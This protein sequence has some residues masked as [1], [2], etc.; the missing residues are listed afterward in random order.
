MT[1]LHHALIGVYAPLN[2]DPGNQGEGRREYCLEVATA[3]VAAAMTRGLCGLAAAVILGEDINGEKLQL[4]A[5]FCPVEVGGGGG[6][7][8]A[9]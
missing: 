3:V 9:Q 4:S 7:C 8:G 6:G 2:H 1:V 5:S